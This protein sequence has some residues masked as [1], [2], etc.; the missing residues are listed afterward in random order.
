MLATSGIRICA[1]KLVSI[2]IGINPTTV[3]NDVM[4]IALNRARAALAAASATVLLGLVE[5][6]RELMMAAD[7]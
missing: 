7:I 1:C 4:K 3:V 2:K 6:H 5:I